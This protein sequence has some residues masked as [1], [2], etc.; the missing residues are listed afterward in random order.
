MSDATNRLSNNNT[1]DFIGKVPE[2]LPE[3][4]AAELVET[5][6]PPKV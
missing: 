2:F 6:L 4:M 3:D 1:Q 5:Q